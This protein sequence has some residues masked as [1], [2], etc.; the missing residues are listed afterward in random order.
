MVKI[1]AQWHNSRILDNGS[2][3]KII[4]IWKRLMALIPV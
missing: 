3:K 4:F 2:G 1:F